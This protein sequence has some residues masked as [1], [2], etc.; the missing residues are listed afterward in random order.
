MCHDFEEREA[1]VADC[2]ELV[3][4]GRRPIRRWHKIA[5]AI[6]LDALLEATEDQERQIFDGFE[7]L[8]GVHAAMSG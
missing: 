3:P 2:A 5:L 8:V 4:I 6:D 7:M 1:T